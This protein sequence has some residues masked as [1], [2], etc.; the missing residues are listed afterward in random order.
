MA[1]STGAAVRA[2]QTAK[3][4]DMDLGKVRVSFPTLTHFS[5]S[6]LTLAITKIFSP[7]PV[8][9]ASSMSTQ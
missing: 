3:R 4:D 8:Q 1:R 5:T 2:F 7:L 6:L 9:A